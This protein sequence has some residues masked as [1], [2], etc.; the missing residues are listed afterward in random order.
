MCPKCK[1]FLT[2]H[3]QGGKIICHFCGYSVVQKLD[4]CFDCGSDK[5]LYS[6][7]GTQRAEELLVDMFPSAKIKRLD[8]FQILQVKRTLVPQ[9]VH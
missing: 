2:Y 4:Q 3:N 1:V 7:T 9:A 5:I 8:I 6:G